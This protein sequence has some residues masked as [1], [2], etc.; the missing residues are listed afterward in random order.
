MRETFILLA[1]ILSLSWNSEL[2]YSQV[3]TD[4]LLV[5][6]FDTMSLQTREDFFRYGRKLNLA[7]GKIA[8]EKIIVLAKRLLDSVEQLSPIYAPYKDTLGFKASAL[9]AVLYAT[10]PEF[11]QAITYFQRALSYA[12]KIQSNQYM[13][14]SYN[15]LGQ[16]HAS[17]GEWIPAIGY[18]TQVIESY[19]TTQ[20]PFRLVNQAFTNLGSVYR[21]IGEFESAI[22]Y[23]RKAE[24]YHQRVQHEE[25]PRY[26]ASVYQALAECFK[27]V[28]RQ[29]S[30][31]YYIK[32]LI[33]SVEEMERDRE[34][35][36]LVSQ[37]ELSLGIHSA[38][39]AN[40]FLGQGEIRK[41]TAYY[42]KMSSLKTVDR[43]DKYYLDIRM[44]IER[45]NIARAD[46]LIGNPPADV[47]TSAIKD[48]Y[49]LLSRF[50]EK[51]GDDLKSLAYLNRYKE[52]ELEFFENQQVKLAAYMQE[53]IKSVEQQR[54]IDLLEEREASQ[55]RLSRF[56]YLLSGLLLL[57]LLLISYA[58]FL[59][60]KKNTY[61]S[62]NLSK[63]SIIK[64]QA[65]K[66]QYAEQQ[67]NKLFTN[68]A[69]E[70]Q[71]P[72]NI[73]QGLGTQLAQ[74]RSNT[75]EDIAALNIIVKNSTQLSEATHRILALS[76]SEVPPTPVQL[77]WFSLRELFEYILPEY[78]YLA[79]NKSLRIESSSKPSKDLILYSDVYKIESIL[80]NLLSNSIKYTPKEGIVKITCKVC[81]QDKL[82]ISIEDSGLGIPEED[83]PHVFDRYYQSRSKD[84]EGGF[85]LGLAICKEY[86]CSLGGDIAVK[87]AVPEG[88]IFSITLPVSPDEKPEGVE[89]Y[90]FS[91]SQVVPFEFPE[92]AASSNKGESAQLLIV[93]D[94]LDFCK[95]LELT[96][97]NEYHLAFAHEGEGAL[98][99]LKKHTP[100]LIL[101]DWMM[102]GWDGLKLVSYLKSHESFHH[103]PIVMLTAR[104]LATDKIKALRAGIDDYITKPAE[105]QEIRSRI[106]HII[107]IHEERPASG[108]SESQ[109]YEALSLSDQDWLMNIELLI[110][111]ML[112]DFDLNIEKI[113]EV[114]NLSSRQFNRKIKAMTGLSTKKYIQELRFWEA[115]RMLETK[116]Y[117]SVKAVSLSVGFKDPKGFS[118]R[119]RERFGVYPSDLL[120]KGG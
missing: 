71:T 88:A 113:A 26:L 67:K 35:T 107:R 118:R 22:R 74:G 23:L 38:Y 82:K 89:L 102:P 76:A 42:K 11:Q 47:D 43:N 45:D 79:K 117:D 106:A 57:L 72:L 13:V 70:F 8:P 50:Y 92:L 80:K 109:A 52:K 78:V 37:F 111:P 31:A 27:D 103:I 91:P 58:Y 2:A 24:A 36:K 90:S 1:A 112:N 64:E 84:P 9:T 12:E 100:G 3:N 51:N 10:L 98:V 55:R 5:A 59:S 56:T 25:S 17:A 18:F 7:E 32:R 108:V 105:S 16:M 63:S 34:N 14:E 62:E 28:E 15:A 66:L 49:L 39:L 30:V 115:R 69:H 53:K 54:T 46:E 77:Q 6:E 65:E 21:E 83:L 73:I 114:G 68:I 85:G 75:G 86:V 81:S 97:A 101:T 120:N 33:G 41:A 119:F 93:E 60:R 48:F 4:S 19:D 44:S 40:H 110:T 116:E 96:L 20:T 104:N 94:N 87:N 95:F 99:Y 61:L 29:D